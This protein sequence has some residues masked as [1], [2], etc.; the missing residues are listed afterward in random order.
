MLSYMMSERLQFFVAR[1]GTSRDILHYGPK[2]TPILSG[3]LRF[4][5]TYAYDIYEFSMTYASPDRLILNSEQVEWGKKES[6]NRK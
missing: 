4:E 6:V 1:S 5:N 2:K 3:T